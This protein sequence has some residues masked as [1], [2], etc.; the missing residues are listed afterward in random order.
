MT[1]IARITIVDR[2]GREVSDSERDGVILE[3]ASGKVVELSFAD[4]ADRTR[5][6]REVYRQLGH[7]LPASA[8]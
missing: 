7:L 1:S 3:L 4:L 6:R 5:T 8:G 2:N